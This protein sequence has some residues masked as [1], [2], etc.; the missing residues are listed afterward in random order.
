MIAGIRVV[1][2]A[3]C[4]IAS[5]SVVV[6]A[7]DNGKSK[8]AARAPLMERFTCRTG[9]NDEQARRYVASVIRK[10]RPTH[11]ITHWKNSFHRD[12]STTR[13]VTVDAVL[14]AELEGVPVE[15]LPHRGVRGIYYA[16]NWEDE[17]GFVPYLYVDVTLVF[18]QWKKAVTKYQFIRGGV[19]PFAYLDYYEAL[20][21]V[22]GARS[23]KRYAVALDVDPDARK[24]VAGD[25]R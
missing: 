25:L 1:A 4:V 10:V 22:R 7:A 21:R 15:G 9:P 8:P 6:N 18:E 5:T 3:V 20:A 12:H 24:L 23:G 14:L 2:A 19:S 13:A 16:E 17:E 11:I